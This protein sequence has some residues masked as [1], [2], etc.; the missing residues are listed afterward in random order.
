MPMSSDTCEPPAPAGQA[1]APA[2]WLSLA[3]APTFVAMAGLTLSAGKAQMICAADQDTFP[4]AGMTVMYLLMSAFH[5]APWL[6]F[7]RR[8]GMAGSETKPSA[9]Y[10]E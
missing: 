4:L 5:L 6:R 9:P 10:R 7:I 2:D 8:T 1:L 3:A